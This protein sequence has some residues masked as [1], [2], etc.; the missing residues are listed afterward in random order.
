[1]LTGASI[2][3]LTYIGFDGISTLSE[4]VENP[5]RNILLATVLTCLITGVLASMLVYAAQ[6]VWGNWTGFPDVDTAFIHVA[7]KA[8]GAW[9]FAIDQRRRC[10]SPTSAPARAR[11]W[12]RRGCSTAWAAATRCRAGFSPRS[13]RG[14]GSR[15]TTCCSSACWRSRAD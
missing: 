5:R 8:G 15:A 1:M 3:C 9:L 12:A 6:L 11:I 13:M 4:E 7:G 14:T 2:A 10:W